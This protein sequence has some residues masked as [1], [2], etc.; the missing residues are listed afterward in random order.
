[1]KLTITERRLLLDILDMHLVGMKDAK[2]Q[3]IEDTYSLSDFD[4]FVDTLQQHDID[5]ETVKSICRK[6]QEDGKPDRGGQ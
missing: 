2:E 4:T 6:V 1:M 3:M 5:V